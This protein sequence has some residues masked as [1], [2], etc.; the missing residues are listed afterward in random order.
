MKTICGFV[1]WI[2]GM[3]LGFMVLNSVP[4]LGF[5]LIIG[6]LFLG[7]YIGGLIE[8]EKE[9]ERR[10]KEEQAR[11]RRQEENE[12]E[13]K[14]QRRN[15][16]LSLARKYP[17][18]TKYYF[19]TH[20]GIT[21]S[22]ISD[23]DI[24]DDKVDTLLGHKYSYERDELAHNAAYKA[25]IEAEQK[26]K[27]RQ[28]EQ[29]KKEAARRAEIARKKAEEERKSLPNILL[30]C[31]SGWHSHGYYGSIKHK[32]FIDYYPYNRYK[33]FATASMFADWKLVWN[34]KND[35]RISP[36]EHSFALQKVI[37]LTEDTLRET[38]G[39]RVN[40]LTLVCLTASTERNTK[41]RFEEFSK[42][43]CNDLGMDN[44]FEHIR[45]T[46]DAVPK[47]IGG[48]GKAKKQYDEWFFNGKFIILFD[49]VRTSGASLEEEKSR[50]E[51]FGAKIIGA[52][53]IAQT[54]S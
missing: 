27:L 52:I 11:K 18:A 46:E 12:R 19:R 53:T 54:Q 15:E 51:S 34:F 22:V 42:R 47:H 28:E 25:K 50:L 14:K 31:V 13:R 16:A 8:Q 36:T 39:N 49:D 4:I 48:T 32:W 23:Y 20:W 26:E 43:V 29:E 30:S 5:A 38:F 37:K 24:T 44:G 6:G 2:V 45:I 33:D 1:G 35:D 21:K 10:A 17:E 9:K 3:L 40:K 41:R 7:R